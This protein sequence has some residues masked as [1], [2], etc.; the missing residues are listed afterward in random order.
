[1]DVDLERIR[2]RA[3]EIWESEGRRGDPMEHW[4]R[5][6]RE[7]RPGPGAG[8]TVEAARPADAAAALEAITAADS[9]P[10]KRA[11]KAP[12]A[13]KAPAAAKPAPKAPAKAAVE[14]PE[15]I[16]LEILPDA[17]SFL[18]LPETLLTSDL[19]PLYGRPPDARLPGA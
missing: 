12:V 19:A 16:A 4:L 6:E 15:T 1:M 9:A 5:A 17:R 13:A 10:K 7:M 11:A 3:Y 14:G 8:A 2:L 18:L